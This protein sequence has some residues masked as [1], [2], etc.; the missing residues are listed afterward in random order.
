MIFQ[1]KLA[2]KH[3]VLHE[4]NMNF[5][6]SL[7]NN[8]NE[9]VSELAASI[10]SHSCEK[11]LEQKA[12][13]DV[14]VLERLVS[15]LKGSLSQRDS[16]LDSIAAIIKNNS[17]VA[18]KFAC[19]NYGKA[20]A[21]L[22][23][24]VQDRSPRTRLLASVCLIAIGRASPCHA[25]A[26]QTKTKLILTLV[27]LLEEPGRVGDDAPFALSDL[28]A[29][30]EELH[31]QA[32]SVIAI[33]KL[34]NFLKKGTVQA[35]RF[36]GILLSLAEFC[37]KLEKCRCQLMSMEVLDVITDA[38]KH[39]SAGVRVASCICLRSISRSVKNLSAGNFS[40]ESVL[41]PLFQQLNDFSTSVQ[42]AALDAVCNLSTDF[43]LQK[44]P[45]IQFGGVTLLVE[46]SRSMDSVIRLKSLCALRNLMFL[47]DK[48]S[49]QHILMELTVST[50]ASLLSGS[51]PLIQEQALA[52]IS[53]FTSG[54]LDNIEYVI[55]EDSNIIAVAVRQLHTVSSPEV[56]V[57]VQM[58]V[59]F[60]D[61]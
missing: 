21:S 18:T 14:G 12:L 25:Q 39:D 48:I 30:E 6:L 20:L 52:F 15:L 22:T 50:L 7:L 3:N 40:T 49:R 2:P 59:A 61:M 58:L 8:E 31:K 13:C 42:V 32:V 41:V 44:S 34:C 60:H 1:S 35:R 38:L 17:E 47:G 11:Y 26:L 43:S 46:L 53:N 57:Q 37:S 54:C 56:C 9:N 45:S 24:L 19:M 4:K 33:E 36:E 10:I 29:G 23:E 27:E 28:V 51:E 16:C 55:T 5:L